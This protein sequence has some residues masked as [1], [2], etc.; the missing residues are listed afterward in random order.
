M[1]PKLKEYKSLSEVPLE[2]PE[3]PYM[4]VEPEIICP[5]ACGDKGCLNHDYFDCR[6]SRMK[7]EKHA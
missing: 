6:Y 5:H 3:V 2:H 1:L 4:C 7:T